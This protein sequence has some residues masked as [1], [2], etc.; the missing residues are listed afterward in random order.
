M[1]MSLDPS[2]TVVHSTMHKQPKYEQL[3]DE[4]QRHFETTDQNNAHYKDSGHLPTYDPGNILHANRYVFCIHQTELDPAALE[5][6]QQ[7]RN[8]KI[9]IIN[10]STE[11]SLRQWGNRRWF[12]AQRAPL[13]LRSGYR[14]H[15]PELQKIRSVN[16]S[17]KLILGASPTSSI[18]LE[19]YWKSDT[20]IP[21]INQFFV[22]HNLNC[23]RWEELYHIWYTNAIETTTHD[24]PGND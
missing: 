12:F 3:F 9:F 1:V 6:L 4:Y 21:Q 17:T 16:E 19:D 2:V 22:A 7:C 10:I 24:L 20:A 14:L 13:S 11:E 8:L 5:L 15:A 23:I 18:E